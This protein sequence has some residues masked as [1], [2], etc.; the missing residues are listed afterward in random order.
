MIGLPANLF[1]GTG[2]PVAILIFKRNKADKKVLFVD[3]SREFRSGTTQNYLREQDIEKILGTY[4]KRVSVDKYAYLT[5]FD[6]LKE[7]DFN[8]NIPRYVDTFEPE[9]LVDLVTVNAEINNLNT[10]LKN[11][12]EKVTGYL[13]ELGLDG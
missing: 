1:Y 10:E 4:Q 2:I 13:K 9:P 12:E 11:V 6:E 5:D 3:A 7:N 8:L